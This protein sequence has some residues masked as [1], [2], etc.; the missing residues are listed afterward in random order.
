MIGGVVAYIL[1]SELGLGNGLNQEV[2]ANQQPKSIKWKSEMANTI[3]L[4]NE[5][6]CNLWLRP[7]KMDISI[8]DDAMHD[9]STFCFSYQTISCIDFYF[10]VDKNVNLYSKQSPRTVELE[11]LKMDHS[12]FK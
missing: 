9:S 4:T 7:E 2:P 5:T 10:L 6:K 3:P 8:N 12:P 11:S 1:V